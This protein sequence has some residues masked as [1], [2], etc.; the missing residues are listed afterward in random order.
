MNF[1]QFLNVEKSV[2]AI[3][4]EHFGRSD[5]VRANAASSIIFGSQN[6]VMAYLPGLGAEVSTSER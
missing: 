6:E 4:R 5:G 1:V 3:S 2:A